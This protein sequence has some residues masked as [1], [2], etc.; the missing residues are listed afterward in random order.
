MDCEVS[1][2]A[3]DFPLRGLKDLYCV[4]DLLLTVL[5][6]SQALFITTSL[7]GVGEF[8]FLMRRR[9]GLKLEDVIC[10]RS[11]VEKEPVRRQI[12]T[13]TVIG[14]CT[15]LVIQAPGSFPQV[16]PWQRDIALAVVIGVVHDDEAALVV[17]PGPGKSNQ[18]VPA[19][20]A[21][22]RRNTVQQLPL[23]FAKHRLL[24]PAK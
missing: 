3:G 14:R 16:L 1:C 15:H 5:S 24:Q 23:T 20:V 9:H 17:F 6:Y 4:T 22:P 7:C 13:I 2:H 18:G 12:L 8:P 19:F 21:L 10:P 11:D